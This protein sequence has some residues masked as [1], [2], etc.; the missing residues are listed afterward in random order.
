MHMINEILRPC[1]SVTGM[2]MTAKVLRVSFVFC[3]CFRDLVPYETNRYKVN[4]FS[5]QSVV[6]L[7]IVRFLRR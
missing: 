2:E 6:R 5:S 3:F 1:Q 7:F 4:Y